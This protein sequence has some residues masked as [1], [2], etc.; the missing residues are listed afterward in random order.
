MNSVIFLGPFQ[1]PSPSP[2][3]PLPL[4]LPFPPLPFP[5]LSY[6][7]LPYSYSY[8][9]SYSCSALRLLILASFTLNSMG[10]KYS[11]T[12]F[13]L[14]IIIIIIRKKIF[15]P[16]LRNSSHLLFVNTIHSLHILSYL[17]KHRPLHNLHTFLLRSWL[18]SY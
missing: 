17:S 12:E 8:S 11:R 6:A 18:L 4:P 15:A 13:H 10:K 3:P 5:F 7:I 2:S 1:L 9:Y 14:V 16:S